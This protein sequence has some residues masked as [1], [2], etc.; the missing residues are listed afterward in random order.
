LVGACDHRDDR[1]G[2]AWDTIR[3]NDACQ[4]G[5]ASLEEVNTM[6][7]AIF[8]ETQV[9]DEITRRLG[10]PNVGPEGGLFHADGPTDTG[11]WW[12]FEVWESDEAATRF[13]D[14]ILK[15]ALAH[16]GLEPAP[17]RRLEVTWHSPAAPQ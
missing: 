3:S 10:A 12:I 6:A 1:P 15:P 9:D 4:R 17:S 16:A 13:H 8:T 14:G 2:C 7:V 11:G 5:D